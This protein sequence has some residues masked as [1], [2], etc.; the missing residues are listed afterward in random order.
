VDYGL[1]TMDYGFNEKC[2][3]TRENMSHSKKNDGL[4]VKSDGFTK[5][6]VLGLKNGGC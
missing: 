1:G 3:I 6:G 5:N 2:L 4:G